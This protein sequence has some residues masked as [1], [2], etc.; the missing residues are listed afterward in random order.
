M[1][2]EK[3][4]RLCVATPP[5]LKVYKPCSGLAVPSN[6]VFGDKADA[7]VHDVEVGMATKQRDMLSWVVITDR[8]VMVIKQP[9]MRAWPCLKK[10]QEDMPDFNPCMVENGRG[11]LFPLHPMFST[12]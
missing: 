10:Q 12:D 2:S 6:P 4:R 8:V 7:M 11:V 3:K 1:L 9:F 5:S